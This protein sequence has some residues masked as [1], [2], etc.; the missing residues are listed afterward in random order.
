MHI[1]W[2]PKSVLALETPLGSTFINS[3]F[4]AV[5]FDE[6]SFLEGAVRLELVI[7]AFAEPFKA[8]AVIS[9]S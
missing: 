4:L 7:T 8:A 1:I 3:I 2:A 9:K 5:F 6:G